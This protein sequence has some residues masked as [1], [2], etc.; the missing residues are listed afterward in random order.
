MEMVSD[1]RG[2]RVPMTR[3]A[4]RSRP[5]AVSSTQPLVTATSARSASVA[6]RSSSAGSASR[7][8][9]SARTQDCS[10]PGPSAPMASSVAL[11]DQTRS[12]QP[13]RSRVAA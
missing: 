9:S 13:M 2:I 10:G 7:S 12:V 11:Y 5:F 4:T 6:S 3:M 1:G 8:G